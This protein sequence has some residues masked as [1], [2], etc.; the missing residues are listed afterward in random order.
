MITGEISPRGSKS[1]AMIDKIVLL[2]IA[3]DDKLI[4]NWNVSGD[5]FQ[6]SPNA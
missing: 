5:G 2:V 3:V 6:H 4:V 1:F